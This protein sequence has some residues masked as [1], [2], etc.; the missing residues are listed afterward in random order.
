M[1]QHRKKI[2][3]EPPD[4]NTDIYRNRTLSDPPAR[5]NLSQEAKA[6][7]CDVDLFDSSLGLVEQEVWRR[8]AIAECMDDRLLWPPCASNGFVVSLWLQIDNDLFQKKH[9]SCSWNSEL[10]YSSEG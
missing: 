1:R 3:S 10:V 4:Y 8:A 5:I 2:L 7:C 6:N 9:N